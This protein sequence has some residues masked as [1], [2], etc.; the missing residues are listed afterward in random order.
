MEMS[1]SNKGFNLT[2]FFVTILAANP[3][4]RMAPTT[5]LGRVDEARR[6]TQCSMDA[7]GAEG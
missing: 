4:A 5:R 3:G 6:L 7:C 2:R 1:S